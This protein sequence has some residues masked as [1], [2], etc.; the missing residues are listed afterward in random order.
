MMQQPVYTVTLNPGLDRTL[1]VPAI[2]YNEVLRASDSRLD[3]GGKGFNVSRALNA[4]GVESVAI[5]Y[6]GGAVGRMLER[7]LNE[8]GIRTDFVTVDG[9]T[10]TNTVIAEAGTDRY[11]KVNEA[12]PAVS[13]QAQGQLFRRVQAGV[14]PGSIWVLCGSLP[15]GVPPDVYA[16]LIDAVQAGGG[17]AILDA[18]G[19]ALRLGVA[20]APYLVKPNAEEAQEMTG[21]PVQSVDDALDAARRFMAAGAQRVALS[22][23]AQ[24]VVYACAEGAFHAQPPSVAART[25]VGVGD[26]LL[27]G[28][29]YAVGRG[30]G[31]AETARWGVAAG[32][33][34]A[35]GEGV[36]VGTLREVT[37]LFERV[38]VRP[39][40]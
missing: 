16:R 1:T 3:W 36:S 21:G 4:L 38:E 40:V 25:V 13:G 6:A 8:L 24:G 12:G 7:G 5:G 10:R 35:M 30:L 18:S 20:A 32:T 23:G 28:L 9:E 15:P 26:A 33:A 27:A 14:T 19:E 34:A 11:V 39:L 2:R 17:R 37:T 29:V 22:L 31:V